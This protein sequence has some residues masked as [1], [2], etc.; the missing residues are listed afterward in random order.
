MVM[1]PKSSRSI[2]SNQCTVG[3]R[4]EQEAEED[5]KG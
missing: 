5:L 2:L 4:K 3:K 1:P